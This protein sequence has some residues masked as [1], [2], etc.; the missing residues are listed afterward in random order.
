MEPHEILTTLARVAAL[1]AAD[2]QIWERSLAT[3]RLSNKAAALT[4]GNGS[5]RVRTMRRMASSAVS[6]Q[7]R[8]GRH[9]ESLAG[10]LSDDWHGSPI[11]LKG[12]SDNRPRDRDARNHVKT[13]RD[14]K[15]LA[16]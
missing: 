12:E 9:V 11:H 10:D 4:C 14:P 2:P 13:P 6:V 8:L 3:K 15:A 16:P 5:L 1:L 7:S